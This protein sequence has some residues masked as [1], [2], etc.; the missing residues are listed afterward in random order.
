VETKT[1]LRDTTESLGVWHYNLN[2]SGVNLDKVSNA[3]DIV[4]LS[5]T[6][7]YWHVSGGSE[8]GFADGHVA[9]RPDNAPGQFRVSMR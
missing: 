2:L 3:A 7:S 8:Y 1:S 9:W 5:D 6:R 4:M